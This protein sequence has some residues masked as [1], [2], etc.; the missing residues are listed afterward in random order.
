VDGIGLGAPP[1][2]PALALLAG[3]AAT[4]AVA[5]L[6]AAWPGR[7]AARTRPAVALRSE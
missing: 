4:V 2:T 7:V 6:V 5:N 3:V 1:V